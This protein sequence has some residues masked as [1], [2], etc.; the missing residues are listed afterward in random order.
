VPI[1]VANAVTVPMTYLFDIVV[2][3]VSFSTLSLAGAAVVFAAFVL[4][5]L[6]EQHA[7]REAAV[8]QKVQAGVRR[9]QER[10]PSRL[11]E[12]SPRTVL[13]G[14]LASARALPVRRALLL[15]LLR[16]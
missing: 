7:A 9:E 10:E 5:N 2:K 6:H 16:A 13:G 8:R 1:I 12:A 11:L 14:H 4:L 15:P 3:G